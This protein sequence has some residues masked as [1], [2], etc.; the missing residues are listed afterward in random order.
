LE[1]G[2]S[3]ESIEENLPDLDTPGGTDWLD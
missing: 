3:P 1:A 2:E